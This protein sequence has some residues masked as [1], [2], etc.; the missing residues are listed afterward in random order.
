MLAFDLFVGEF[1]GSIDLASYS[2]NLIY[3]N[4]FVVSFVPHYLSS[5]ADNG[6]FL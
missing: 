1:I 2:R 4:G 5:I 6:S 3:F